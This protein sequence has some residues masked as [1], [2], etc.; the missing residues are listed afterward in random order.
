VYNVGGG[1]GANF[2]HPGLFSIAGSTKSASTVDAIEAIRKEIDRIRTTSVTDQEL[3]YAKGAVLNS[4]VFLF[5]HPSKTL[6]RILTYEYY[7][8]PRDFIF[9]HQKAIHAVTKEDILRAAKQHIKP[10]ILTTVAAGKPADFGKPLTT[11]GKVQDIDLTIPEPGSRGAGTPSAKADPAAEAKGR[12]LIERARKALGPGPRD[13][14]MSSDATM[15][16]PQGSMPVKQQAWII[17]PAEIRSEQNLPFGKVTVYYDGK[18]GG[19]MVSP[20]GQMPLPP[21][22]VTQ[23]RQQMF[24]HLQGLLR[25]DYKAM[26]VGPNVIEVSGGDALTTRIEFDANGLPARQTYRSLP[27]TGEPATVTE[28][29]SDW[30]EAGSVRYPGRIVIE[31]NGNKAMEIAVTEYRV[32]TGLKSEDLSKKQ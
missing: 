16:T 12:E 5:D 22:V 13:I 1:W 23:V 26:T 28:T 25:G 4:F 24:R 6:N 15:H 14:V 8:Y 27:V 21:P 18:G 20:Q 7:G 9:Q 17:E 19:W 31:Q 3:E 32:N 11:L 30:K 10:D 29:Y 2:N